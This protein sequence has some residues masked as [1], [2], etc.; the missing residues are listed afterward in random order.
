MIDVRTRDDGWADVTF[1]LPG[2]LAGRDVHVVG[3][4]NGWDREA[5]PL[6]EQD[7]VLVATVRMR[8]GRRYRFRYLLDRERWQNDWEAHDYEPNE[9]G[10]DDSVVD[11]TRVGD[12]AQAGDSSSP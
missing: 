7:G 10:G 2:E 1:R 3:E 9:F 6:L 12:D 11:V 8:F 5:T 4:F